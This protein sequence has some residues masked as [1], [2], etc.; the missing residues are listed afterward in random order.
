MKKGR[1]IVIEDGA[2][3]ENDVYGRLTAANKAAISKWS[4]YGIY[5]DDHAI[6]VALAETGDIPEKAFDSRKWR[7]LPRP[8]YHKSF[9]E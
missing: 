4:S 2:H 3:A 1:Y 8:S 9:L 5:G 7:Q 6:Y